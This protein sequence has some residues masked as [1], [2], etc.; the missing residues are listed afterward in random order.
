[1]TRKIW[2]LQLSIYLCFLMFLTG[3]EQSVP[4][5]QPDESWA[6]PGEISETLNAH[7]YFDATLS[8][9]GFVNSERP[10]HYKQTCLNLKSVV[11]VGGWSD[12]LVISLLHGKCSF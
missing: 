2:F 12:E 6:P 9:Q 11:T 4:E 3:C 5:F 1:M 8:M 10:T 7:I